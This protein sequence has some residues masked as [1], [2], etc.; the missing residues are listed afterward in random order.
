MILNRQDFE[1]GTDFELYVLERMRP[2]VNPH[3]GGSIDLRGSTV[4]SAALVGE[5]ISGRALDDLKDQ[6]S[7]LLFGAAWK[8]LDLLLEFALNTAGFSPAGQKWSITKKQGHASNGD[9]D[10][11]AVLG[12]SQE[13]W[14][15]LLSV[16]ANTVEHR[17][18]L[19]HRT[20]KVDPATGTLDGV[21]QNQSPLRSL[22]LDQQV[23][24]AKAAALACRGVLRGSIDKRSED[25]LKYQLNQLTLHTGAPTFGVGAA[26]APV[27]IYLA[28]SQENGV[29][30]LDMAGVLERARRMCTAVSH[31]NILVDVPDGSSRKLFGYG[32][33]CPPGRSAV[34]LTALPPWLTYR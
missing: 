11:G 16:Y 33:D 7:P 15:A 4:V 14:K 17:H 5:S 34:D 23:A 31:F 3:A 29:Y 24:L 20:A 12:C 27:D 18:C 8:V 28:L 25:H 21:D 9:G 1:E 32:E 13:V 6:L 30:F 19:V 22:T 26:S 10:R 2:A